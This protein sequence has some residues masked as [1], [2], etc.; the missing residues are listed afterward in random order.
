[1]AVAS[2]QQGVLGV[3]LVVSLLLYSNSLN[4]H[5]K[6]PTRRLLF[7]ICSMLCAAILVLTPVTWWDSLRWHNRPSFWERSLTTYGGLG[8]AAPATWLERLSAWAEPLGRLFGHPALTAV[9]LAAAAASL[10]LR[11]RPALAILGLY[12]LGYAGLHLIVSFRPWD[13][14]LLPA[15]PL[16]TILAADG[17]SA[18][19]QSVRPAALRWLAAGGLAAALLWAASLGAAGR[20]PIG[21][22]AGAF[23]GAERLAAALARQPGEAVIYYRSLGWH[24]DF[25]L[26]DAAQERRWWDTPGELAQKAAATAAAEPS[27]PQLLALTD[28]EAVHPDLRNAL[29]E[30]RLAL[31]QPI[32]FLRTDGSRSLVIYRIVEAPGE[33]TDG[34]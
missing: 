29:A 34:G 15:L 3:P 2:K 31:A 17:L 13:R 24:L 27:R 5:G 4:T 10:L 1:L 26:F 19:W 14:Y 22:G 12:V 6:T 28:A 23:A 9:L 7:A 11:K 20:L 16:V 25:Y 32:P 33:R 21:S 30:R 18:L 8:L